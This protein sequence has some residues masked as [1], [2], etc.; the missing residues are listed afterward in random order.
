LWWFL[1]VISRDHCVLIIPEDEALTLLA[2]LSFE[3]GHCTLS[4]CI[5]RLQFVF[6]RKILISITPHISIG[7]VAGSLDF[8]SVTIGSILAHLELDVLTA[9]DRSEVTPDLVPYIGNLRVV[10][11]VAFSCL[12]TCEIIRI[13]ERAAI[14]AGVFD[15]ICGAYKEGGCESFDRVV[16]V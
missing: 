1:E 10:A 13:P 8:D 7:E 5:V 16:H 9:E 12:T 2:V 6:C 15:C 4:V 14:V 11:I 3:E